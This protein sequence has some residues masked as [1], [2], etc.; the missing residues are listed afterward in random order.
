MFS[1][2]VDQ[3]IDRIYIGNFEAANNLRL[4]KD[5]GFTHVL[6]T[7]TKLPTPFPKHFTYLKIEVQDAL[8]EDI[9]A[10]F[11]QCLEFMNE[12]LRG[13]DNSILVHCMQGISRSPTIVI[14]YL[15]KYKKYNLT[16]ALET[17]K[18]RR[19]EVKPNLAFMKQL[20]AYDDDLQMQRQKDSQMGCACVLL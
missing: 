14:A 20:Q 13:R 18:F 10:H 19:P 7:A 5:Y 8:T 4:M 3:I 9:R 2:K 1:Y 12:A 15:M 16:R 17:V 6:V 11:E